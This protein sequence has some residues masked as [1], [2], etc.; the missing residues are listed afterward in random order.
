[1]RGWLSSPKRTHGFAAGC[2]HDFAAS[3]GASQC[4]RHVQGPQLGDERS[5][6]LAAFFDHC[7]PLIND[8]EELTALL[9]GADGIGSRADGN[10]PRCGRRAVGDPS[11]RHSGPK[12]FYLHRLELKAGIDAP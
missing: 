4:S 7:D 5:A 1:M 8:A 6:R 2:R 9:I 10:M 3:R 11:A 12:T